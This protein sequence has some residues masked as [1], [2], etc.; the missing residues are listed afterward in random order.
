VAPL[1]QKYIALSQQIVFTLP[2][3]APLG[4]NLRPLRYFVSPYSAHSIQEY[5]ME[6]FEVAHF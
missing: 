3:C 4:L 2:E 5:E 1:A 6:H